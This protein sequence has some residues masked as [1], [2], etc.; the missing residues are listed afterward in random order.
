M[1]TAAK[2]SQF[3][4]WG[5]IGAR[6]KKCELPA[7]DSVYVY[8]HDFKNFNLTDPAAIAPLYRL[9]GVKVWQGYDAPQPFGVATGAELWV[10]LMFRRDGS[11]SNLAVIDFTRNEHGV[12]CWWFPSMPETTDKNGKHPGWHPCLLVAVPRPFVAAWLAA[13]MPVDAGE[14]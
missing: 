11:R 12:Y 8:G 6:M 4:K 2:T 7:W 9:H 14:K 5:H 3:L 1:A 10:R 13:V